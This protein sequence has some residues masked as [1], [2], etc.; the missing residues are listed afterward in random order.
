MYI[1]TGKL[2][3]VI[4]EVEELIH[5]NWLLVLDELQCSEEQHFAEVGAV[6][7]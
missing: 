2:H 5:H 1:R 6:R 3:N 7:K 4:H